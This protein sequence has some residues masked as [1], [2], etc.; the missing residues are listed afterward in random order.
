M[1]TSSL[2]VISEVFAS[3]VLGP[4]ELASGRYTAANP[5][6]GEISVP[7]FTLA[8]L[9]PLRPLH[10][11]LEDVVKG[12]RSS[13]RAAFEV[14]LMQDSSGKAGDQHDTG[15]TPMGGEQGC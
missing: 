14:S 1:Y 15:G 12:L 7:R 6:G 4:D 3:N 8:Q 9:T 10:Q 2:Y 13:E 11:A 5:T